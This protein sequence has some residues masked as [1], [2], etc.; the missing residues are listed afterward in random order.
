MVKHNNAVPNIHYHKEWQL[1]VRTWFNQPARKQRRQAARHAKTAKNGSK[2]IDKLRP[3]A[4]CQSQKYNYRV[5]AGRGFSVEELK[6]VGLT[7][8]AART[9]GISVD[10]RRK[11]RSEEGL[12]TNV[13]RL[14]AYM[15]KL[16]VLPRKSNRLKKGREGV[17]AD[18]SRKDIAGKALAKSIAAALP[19]TN[20]YSVLVN[21]PPEMS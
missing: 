18:T 15:E 6:A 20:N 5:R 11:N 17:P 14:K 21:P 19:I 10:L 2:P 4:R 13:Q 16:V 8:R 1:H 7:P 9:I 12:Q 3:I